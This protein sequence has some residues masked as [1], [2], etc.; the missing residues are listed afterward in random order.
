MDRSENNVH[1]HRPDRAHALCVDLLEDLFDFNLIKSTLCL[2]VY[3]REKVETNNNLT[4][5]LNHNEWTFEFTRDKQK[6]K[7]LTF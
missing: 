1:R 4:D 2:A 5:S 6:N 7:K 3:E